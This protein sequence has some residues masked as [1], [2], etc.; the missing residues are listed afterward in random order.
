MK[1]LRKF[2]NNAEYQAFRDGGNYIT[3]NV[4]YVEDAED[5]VAKPYIP[6][7]LIT[8]TVAG[9]EYQ[10]EEGMTW[11]EWCN[12]EY[13]TH[14]FLC[15]LN[16]VR[17]D[18]GSTIYGETPSDVIYDGNAYSSFGYL[19]IL[20]LED[21][22]QAKLSK[23]TISYSLDGGNTWTSLASNTYTPTVNSGQTIMFKGN[24]T[25]NVNDGVGTFTITKK[26]NLEG[27]CMSLLF[28]D[29]VVNNNSL[30]GKSYTFQYLF[31]GCTSIIQV[32]ESFLPATTLSSYCYRYMFSNCT[33][34]TT[35]PELPATTLAHW[36]Y[37]CMFN[38]CTS[39]T[40]A[41]ELPATTLIEG[42]YEYM[43]SNCT[44]LITAPELPATILAGSCYYG[45]FSKT[46][47]LPNCS[48]IDFN[49]KTVLASGGLNG[50]FAGTKVTDN[51]LYNI[52]PINPTTGKYWLPATTLAYN[53]YSKM[54]SNCTSLTTAPELPATTLSDFC[55]NNMF[56]GCTSLTTAPELPAITLDS[57]CYQSMFENCTSL[58]TAP[59]L[60][61]TT[62]DYLCYGRMFKGCTSLT[63]APELPATAL[64]G[65]CYN[66]MFEG[67]TSLTTAPE[68]PATTLTYYCYQGM[69]YNCASLTTAPELPAITLDS[70]CY[71]SMFYGCTSLTTAPELPATILVS[72]CYSNMF[73]NC[74][75]LTTAPEL[76]AIT[77]D[78]NC[79]QSMFENCTS[80]TTAPELPAT[81]LS[82]NCYSYMF[83]G[84]SGLT[85]APELPATTLSKNCYSYMFRDCSSLTIAPELPA[86]TLVEYCYSNMFNGCT[87]L[88]YIKMLATNISANY[89][90]YNWV[91][92][93][94]KT[95][96]FVKHLDMT[97]LP[98]G[99]S[100]IPDG[101]TVQDNYQPTSYYNLQITADDVNGKKTNTTIYWIC[102]SDGI[103]LCSNEPR[104]G[105]Q[106]SGTSI[107][108]EFPQNTSE[109]NTVE[110]VITFEYQGLTA[111]TTITQGVW[112]DKSYTIDLN[113]N[114]EQS[115][116]ISNP[117]SSLYDGV[118][119]SYSNKGVNNSAAKMY[120]DIDGYTNFKLYIRSYAESN[121][122]YVMVSQLDQDINS[123]T[124]Y[125]NTTLVKA[126]T[127]GKQTSGTA[128]S[129]YTL[130]EF[131]GIDEGE[132]RITIIYRKDSSSSSGDDRGYVLIPKEQ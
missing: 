89:C 116:S 58:T 12:S 49:S 50:L 3:P 45:M 122:D 100:G 75:S 41:P 29:D 22:L 46:N 25:P 92:N 109:T 42:C 111:T 26:C 17:I 55:Y 81:T 40:I 8:F 2:K 14:E 94:S 19:T 131:T 10:A 132:H 64:G 88:N 112:K 127:R 129:N 108:D 37:Y 104:I 117:D 4:C 70:N 79:Y 113:N 102:M 34:L 71:Q 125:S 68:L 87:K 91:S 31:S 106:L 54:F 126:H 120:I 101:W 66:Y 84:C 59:E 78:S 65:Y 83:H 99:S 39:L 57:N 123:G 48:N 77:L 52:L 11:A 62:L 38:G 130:V 98:Y 36:C 69:F 82:K 16:N 80:L 1:H 119:Q 27:N 73:Q 24:L 60:P 95:G 107:S 5:I 115:T 9:I 61:A 85:T 20:A 28:G 86:T 110:R 72:Q 32:S 18:Y 105:V 118:Y 93:V 43:F 15:D 63:T 23:N 128:I 97:S 33:S 114:W 67:C 7:V 44:G 51:D 76:P 103:E 124:S 56:Y 121:Y 35:A 6:P 47:V 21:G 53:C 96:T 74:N 90:L 13:N 30:L